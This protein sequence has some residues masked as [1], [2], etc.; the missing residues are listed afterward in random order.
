MPA[1][2]STAAAS[3]QE[4]MPEPFVPAERCSGPH[5]RQSPY[6]PEAPS[7]P[8]LINLGADYALLSEDLRETDSALST[9]LPESRCVSR[10]GFRLLPE[11]PPRCG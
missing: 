5:C 2:R 11:R 1:H 3:I 4:E 9:P 8:T 7:A 10:S 6:V